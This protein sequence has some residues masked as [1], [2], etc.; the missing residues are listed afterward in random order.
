MLIKERINLE[1]KVNPDFP[2][3]IFQGKIDRDGSFVLGYQLE[4]DSDYSFD[5]L[6]DMTVMELIEDNGKV[7][8][9]DC[10]NFLLNNPSRELEEF[11]I[12]EVYFY[13]GSRAITEMNLYFLEEK[14]AFKLYGKLLKQI[15]GMDDW[16][17]VLTEIPLFGKSEEIY[18]EEE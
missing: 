6:S 8:E 3:D 15:S 13:S 17:V 18:N 4:D 2:I 12:Y 9:N 5:S 11:C 14:N 7:N 10:F 1:T 16:Q